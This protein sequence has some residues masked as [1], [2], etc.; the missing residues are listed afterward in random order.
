MPTSDPHSRLG[1][2]GKAAAA[3]TPPG[4]NASVTGSE[5]GPVSVW[6]YIAGLLVTLSGLYAVNFGIEDRSF[7]LLTYGLAVTGY[8]TSYLMRVCRLPLRAL[9]VQ[10]V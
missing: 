7:T 4:Q 5:D 6:L 9:Q 8:L 3:T 2:E 1:T 10:L